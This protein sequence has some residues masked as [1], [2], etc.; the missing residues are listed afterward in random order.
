MASIKDVPF[1]SEYSIHLQ[2][3]CKFSRPRSLPIVA[4]ESRSSSIPRYLKLSQEPNAA[5]VAQMIRITH[6]VK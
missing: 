3:T 2:H 5:T 6:T 4:T 1:V